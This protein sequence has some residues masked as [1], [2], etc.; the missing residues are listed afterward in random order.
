MIAVELRQKQANKWSDDSLVLGSWL[1]C[2]YAEDDDDVF[3]VV[4][5]SWRRKCERGTLKIIL[6]R[7]F[8][9]SINQAVAGLHGLAKYSAINIWSGELDMK[10]HNYSMKSVQH[11]RKQS[12][13]EWIIRFHSVDGWIFNISQN[14][15][16]SFSSQ[17]NF[18]LRQKPTTIK[19]ILKE[20]R[21]LAPLRG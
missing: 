18:Y 4:T 2:V 9:Q 7:N 10:L 3:L 5:Y 8:L 12:R 14:C 20:R 16:C 13:G 1:W 21:S 15:S 17:N 6:C 11:F 19:I